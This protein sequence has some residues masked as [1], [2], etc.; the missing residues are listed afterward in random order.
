MLVKELERDESN[1]NRSRND[2]CRIKAVQDIVGHAN[3]A[4]TRDI[5]WI[6]NQIQKYREH[7]PCLNNLSL[8]VFLRNKLIE[9][10]SIVAVAKELWLEK[11]ERKIYWLNLRKLVA[12]EP[13]W[14]HYDSA[15]QMLDNHDNMPFLLFSPISGCCGDFPFTKVGP[16]FEKARMNRVI[17][18]YKLLLIY[19]LCTVASA[20]ENHNGSEEKK[21]DHLDM[22]EQLFDILLQNTQF[23]YAIK[24]PSVLKAKLSGCLLFRV[25][26]DSGIYVLFPNSGYVFGGMVQAQAPYNRGLD[27]TSFTGWITGCGRPLMYMYE[28]IWQVKMGESPKI[29]PEDGELVAI[30]CERHEVVEPRGSKVAEGDILVWRHRDGQG[31][32]MFIQSVMNDDLVK[33]VECTNYKDGHQEGFQERVLTIKNPNEGGREGVLRLLNQGLYNTYKERSQKFILVE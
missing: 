22:Q 5:V 6:C 7:N 26:S 19:A 13:Y 4:N 24:V 15:I 33:T 29:K 23:V 10:R 21:V 30:L 17:T 20:E 8:K 16:Y 9:D 32:A 27:C 18:V 14:G 12:E 25:F 2:G 1:E 28:K 31:H 11:S 3:Q